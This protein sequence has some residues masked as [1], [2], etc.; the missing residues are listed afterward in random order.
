MKNIYLFVAIFIGAQGAVHAEVAKFIRIKAL[1]ASPKGQY[2]AIEEFGYKRGKAR[3]YSK[4]R[5]MNVWKNQ[6]IGKPISVIAT[7]EDDKLQDIRD[8]AR[9]LASKRLLKYDIST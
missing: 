4:I 2:I 9:N 3:A 8:K 1:G 7:D 6:Y 5:V